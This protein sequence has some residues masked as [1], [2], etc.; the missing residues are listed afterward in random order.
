MDAY[1]DL[2]QECGTS[3]ADELGALSCAR[4]CEISAACRR[5]HSCSDAA[6]CRAASASAASRAL[7]C[8]HSTP[9]SAACDVMA[10]CTWCCQCPFRLEQTKEARPSLRYKHL[11]GREQGCV[12]LRFCEGSSRGNVYLVAAA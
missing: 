7:S 12:V 4:S 8:N 6:R 2:L 1:P 5:A 3:S 10:H 11:G 9:T